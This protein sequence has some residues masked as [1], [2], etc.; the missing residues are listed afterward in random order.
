MECY[1]DHNDGKEVG[2]SHQA[3]APRCHSAS[4]DERLR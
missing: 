4:E 2:Q 3:V 1:E